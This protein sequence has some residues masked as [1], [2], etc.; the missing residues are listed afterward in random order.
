ML[1]SKAKVLPYW[2]D[3]SLFGNMLKLPAENPGMSPQAGMMKKWC[4]LLSRSEKVEVSWSGKC[5][6]ILWRCFWK[7]SMAQMRYI[8]LLVPLL[9][10]CRNGPSNSSGTMV[11]QVRQVAFQWFDEGCPI[12][13]WSRSECL[14]Y[15]LSHGSCNQPLHPLRFREDQQETLLFGYRTHGFS[16]VFL[17]VSQQNRS[18]L[19][20]T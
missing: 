13:I 3:S 2:H 16:M 14:R 15:H 5:W 19:L 17:R 7:H 20:I 4:G 9:S 6:Q 12:R 11:I 8:V 1:P 18:I 10:F